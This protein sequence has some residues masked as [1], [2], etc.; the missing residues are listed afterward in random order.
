MRLWQVS[1]ELWGWQRGPAS[2]GVPPHLL[3]EFDVCF[4]TSTDPPCG[5]GAGCSSDCTASRYRLIA[6]LFVC[7][8]VRWMAVMT[9]RNDGVSLVADSNGRLVEGVKVLEAER[10]DKIKQAHA[11]REW[12][13]QSANNLFEYQQYAATKIFEVRWVDVC[14][15][16]AAVGSGFGQTV[17]VWC[18]CACVR[19]PHQEERDSLK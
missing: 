7:V 5:G 10:Q 8:V 3:A 14:L 16:P 4:C 9:C 2:G 15:M 1:Q 19:C 11:A 12:A 6:P 13:I 18:V 17:S